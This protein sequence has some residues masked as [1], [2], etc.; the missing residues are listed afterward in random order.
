MNLKNS[1]EHSRVQLT[2]SFV[3]GVH[4]SETERARHERLPQLQQGH[5][6]PE[7]G[8]VVRFATFLTKF[9]GKF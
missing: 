8:P 7:R 3:P 6:E 2:G 4:S 1:R 5:E 9:F